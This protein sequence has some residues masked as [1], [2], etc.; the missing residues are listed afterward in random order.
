MPLRVV[1]NGISSVL[2]VP[3]KGSQALLQAQS[4]PIDKGNKRGWGRIELSTD[5]VP[6]NNIY[7]F[8]FDDPAP[9]KSVIITDDPEVTK[10]LQAALSAPA[11]PSQTYETIVL[12]SARTAEI[13]WEETGVIIWQTRLPEPDS[14]GAKQLTA[15]LEQSRLLLFLPPMNPS[16][17]AFGGL[18]WKA[19]QDPGESVLIDWWRNDASLLRAT[20]ASTALPVGELE[21]QRWCLL[22]GESIPLA[23][24]CEDHQ[25]A[26]ILVRSFDENA[27]FLT[28]LPSA[29][30]SSL[31][32]E[33]VVLYALHHHALADGAAS[34][35]NAQQRDAHPDA[36]AEDLSPWKRLALE[37]I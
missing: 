29:G 12:P 2:E 35:G 4:V 6:A 22:E 3:M 23:R 14:T 10:P 21:I 20:R 26:S 15:H 34:L 28:T 25:R 19:W 17:H 8:V 32:R 7:H 5:A 30:T 1:I 27:Y 24:L 11:D 16:A 13:A 33:G 36:L 31:A 37:S 9:L 18:R